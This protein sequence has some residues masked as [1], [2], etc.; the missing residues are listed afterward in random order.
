M[1][2]IPEPLQEA[3]FDVVHLVS[4]AVLPFAEPYLVRDSAHTPR[5]HLD[6]YDIESLAHRR[7]AA[8]YHQNGNPAMA[9]YEE[10]LAQ[11][12]WGQ[13]ERVLRSF[14]R[15]YVCSTVDREELRDRSSAEIVVLPN[16]VRLP[17]PAPPRRPDSSFTFL[18]VG[19]LSYYPNEDALRFFCSEVLPILRRFA[20]QE[21]NL[22]VVGIGATAALQDVASTPEV[23]LIG[24]VPDV[25]PYY[26]EADAV[27][28]PIRAGGGTRIKILEAFSHCRPVVST[29]L[30]MEGIEVRDEEQALIAD[31]AEDFARQ[32]ARLMADAGLRERLAEHALA[33]VSR[34]YTVEAAARSLAHPV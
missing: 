16:T 17:K 6:L 19:T 30:G 34:A 28:V 10:Q 20:P 22:S 23:R 25:A 2:A 4:L 3:R 29:S 9:Q 27:V 18:F 13:E 26:R 24:A 7:I 15:I 8:L 11:Q 31:T 1:S 14:D 32:C 5:R 33:L 21:F 12:A